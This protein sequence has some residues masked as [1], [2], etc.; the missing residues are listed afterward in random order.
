MTSIPSHLTHS[1]RYDL[2]WLRVIAFACLIFYH[3]GM[4]YVTWDFHVKSAHAGP[5]IEWAMM[6]MNPWRLGLLFFISGVAF[7]FAS[8][9]LTGGTVARRRLIRLGLPIVFAMLVVVAPQSYFELRQQGL[10]DADYLAFLSIYLAPG[11]D[12]GLIMPTWNHL[13]YVVYLL[14]YSLMF[15]AALPL[16][17]A[18][19]EG[20]A[21]RFFDV[22]SAGPMRAL[23]LIAVPFIVYRFTLD[24]QF[25]TTHNLVWDWANHAHRLTIFGIGYF[26]AKHDRFWMAVDKVFPWALGLTVGLVLTM[27]PVWAF[28]DEVVETVPMWTV[29]FFRVVRVWYAWL[30]ILTLIGGA[31]RFLNRPSPILTYFNS[32]V[33]AWY[34]VHQTVLIAAIYYLTQHAMPGWVEFLLVALITVIGCHLFY[35]LGRHLPRFLALFFGI[36]RRKASDSSN[37]AMTS[38]QT[39]E[40]P[41]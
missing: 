11:E 26:I 39:A 7:R 2:D 38:D 27:G 30:V 4:G 32:A 33:F 20:P 37:E 19:A 3:V 10:T 28:W 29:E 17:K 25:Q 35:E 34:M 21:K 12:F 31:Q 41:A 5:E 9:R 22:I 13:W 36:E 15:A 24:T 40:R 16:M 23:T 8:D 14:V 1:R 6:L 18:L